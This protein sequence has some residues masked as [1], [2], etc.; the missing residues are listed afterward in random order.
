MGKELDKDWIVN[1]LTALKQIAGKYR[2]EVAPR[3]LQY[4]ERLAK[5]AWLAGRGDIYI[6]QPDKRGYYPLVDDIPYELIK[7]AIR[8]NTSREVR[9]RLW[10]TAQQQTQPFYPR[11]NSP[12]GTL[13]NLQRK[14][15]LEQA[16]VALPMEYPSGPTLLGQMVP[17]SGIS[18]KTV[19]S[20]KDLTPEDITIGD[21]FTMRQ[22]MTREQKQF[23]DAAERWG[24]AKWKMKQLW[25][26]A[27]EIVLG[28]ALPATIAG[29]TRGTVGHIQSELGGTPF[30]VNG[31][32]VKLRNVDARWQSIPTMD[33]K[34][35]RQ[36]LL[37]S[38]ERQGLSTTELPV[39]QQEVR[40]A[41]LN[42][43]RQLS[44]EIEGRAAM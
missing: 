8:K 35:R 41:I 36:R 44:Q 4:L 30:T 1:Y 40:N 19:L 39:A 37:E 9:R 18:R 7:T 32:P 15:L 13:N 26:K 27:K 16:M 43:V 20:M 38:L 31:M 6:P 21:G 14:R 17:G 22:F 34:L 10:Q 12:G 29:F 42:S 28:G 24:D 3:T 5:E 33:L 11:S 2:D 25:D 23:Y